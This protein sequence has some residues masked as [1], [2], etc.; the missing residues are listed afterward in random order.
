MIIKSL[1]RT[2]VAGLILVRGTA[3]AAANS[4]HILVAFRAMLSEINAS[5]KHAANVGV[6]LVE[7]ALHDCVDE[8]TTVEEHTLVGLQEILLGDLL[9]SMSITLPQLSILYLLHLFL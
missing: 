4:V 1:P 5:P 6:A 9:P 2:H 7:S 3:N 8:G